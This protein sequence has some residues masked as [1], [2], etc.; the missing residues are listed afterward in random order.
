M[1]LGSNPRQSFGFEWLDEAVNGG[2]PS[3]SLVYLLGNPGSGRSI[4]AARFLLSNANP[5]QK[6]LWIGIHSSP[7]ALPGDFKDSWESAVEQES[8]HFREMEITLHSEEEILA[9]VQSVIEQ[10]HYHYLVVDNI[11]LLDAYYDKKLLIRLVRLI[12]LKQL[13]VVLI[14]T[15]TSLGQEISLTPPSL[16]KLADALI[17]TRLRI[18]EKG[19][20]C[21]LKVIKSNDPN[22]AHSAVLY[23]LGKKGITLLGPGG[24]EAEGSSESVVEDPERSRYEVVIEVDYINAD[25]ERMVR[26]RA[27]E[28]N[29]GVSDVD[30]RLGPKI[31][32]D[33]SQFELKFREF[34]DGQRKEDFFPIDICWLRECVEQ[35]LI[36]PLDEFFTEQ[37]REQYL[38]VAL[39]QCVVDG[40]LWAIPHRINVGALVYRSDILEKYQFKPPQTWLELRDYADYML[41]REN[42]PNL[43][44]FGFQGASQEILTCNFLEFLWNHGGDV[45][46]DSQHVIINDER[47]VEAL[48]YMQDLIQEWKIAPALVPDMA[49]EK[50]GRY[51][52]NEKLIFMRHWTGVVSL[53]YSDYLMMRDRIQIAPLPTADPSISPQGIL[54]ASCYVIPRYVRGPERLIQFYQR[55]FTPDAIVEFALKGWGCP[56]FRSV[57][58]NPDVLNYR[59]YYKDVP[60]LLKKG[61]TRTAIAYYHQLTK[62]IQA[63]VNLAL[64]KVKTPREALDRVAEE[65]SKN[66]YQRIHSR[67]LHSALKYINDH[68]SEDLS[69]PRVASQCS[70]SP[71]YFGSL[72]KEVTGLNFS[73]YI[74]LKRV[75]KAKL[76]LETSDQNI[77]EISQEAGFSDQSY[78]CQVFRKLTQMTPTQYRMNVLSK[79]S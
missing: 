28:V 76:L 67:R 17:L 71:S 56:A 53:S 52:L 38:P 30:F 40:H 6:G 37:W 72:F 48:Q 46:D 24:Q 29:Q 64:R 58:S 35:D 44:G 25:E 70:L 63:E 21:S 32:G 59:P 11:D 74:K 4:L 7:P 54:G 33:Y 55:L 78:F 5:E 1:S 34:K 68:I 49:E 79:H 36:Y 31:G 66:I 65:L 75:E 22:Y 50:T 73:D 12:R 20:A 47:A 57:Y 10:D 16:V 69:R 18:D 60:E 39:E 27:N 42:D 15:L 13:T 45:Y 14:G 61:R 77:A 26:H 8:L 43:Y 23:Q 41:K 9:E 62:L 3:G 19:N 51:F 2:I